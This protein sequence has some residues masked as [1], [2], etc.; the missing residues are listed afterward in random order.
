MDSGR[1]SIQKVGPGLYNWRSGKFLSSAW[2]VLGQSNRGSFSVSLP[3]LPPFPEQ[4]SGF[5]PKP[6]M[7]L[8]TGKPITK[9]A[10]FSCSP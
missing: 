10:H 3:P 9:V 6:A 7:I 4:G 2:F 5:I 8:A 1:R